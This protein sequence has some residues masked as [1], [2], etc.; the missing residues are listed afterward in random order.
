MNLVLW[1]MQML[2][3]NNKDNSGKRFIYTLAYELLHNAFINTNTFS[4]IIP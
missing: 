3:K 2:E 1:V 4:Q